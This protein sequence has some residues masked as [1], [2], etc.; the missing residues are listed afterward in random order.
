MGSQGGRKVIAVAL[1]VSSSAR[2]RFA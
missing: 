2:K 1:T